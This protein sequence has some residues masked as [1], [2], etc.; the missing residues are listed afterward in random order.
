MYIHTYSCTSISWTLMSRI[1]LIYQNNLGIPIYTTY[2][3]KKYFYLNLVSQILLY[4]LKFFLFH[5]VQENKIW[6][7]IYKSYKHIPFH[8]VDRIIKP[9]YTTISRASLLLKM[10]TIIIRHKNVYLPELCYPVHGFWER[11]YCVLDVGVH[12]VFLAAIVPRGPD[13]HSAVRIR[14]LVWPV[15]VV[16]LTHGTICKIKTKLSNLGNTFI[17]SLVYYKSKTT[18]NF[19]KHFGTGIYIRS[20]LITENKIQINSFSS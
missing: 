11:V 8:A 7:Y 6:L 10:L 17:F 16:W 20:N 13:T 15:V 5:V 4:F 14:H 18:K 12:A 9:Q 1:Q 2:M 19:N 3:F